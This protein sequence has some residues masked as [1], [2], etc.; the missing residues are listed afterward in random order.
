MQEIHTLLTCCRFV[1]YLEGANT[2]GRLDFLSDLLD[3]HF[4]DRSQR[5]VLAGIVIFRL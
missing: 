1:H 5:E 2:P 4:S 3:Q